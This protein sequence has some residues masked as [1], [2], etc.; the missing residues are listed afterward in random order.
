MF[1]KHFGHIETE[2]KLEWLKTPNH[3]NLPK[4]YKAIANA[5]SKYRNQ[6]GFKKSN[7]HLQC[8]IV[9]DEQKL[10]IEYDE[11]QHFTKA[12]KITLE[13]YPSSIYLSYPKQSWITACEKI[14]AKDNSPID[15]DEKRAFYDTVRDIEAFNNGYTLIR[16]KHGDIDWEADGAEKYL[17]KLLPNKYRNNKTQTTKHKIARLIVTGKQ[18]DRSGNPIYKR[19][20]KLLE[21][22]V[23]KIYMKQQFEFILTP[24][25]FLTFEFPKNLHYNIDVLKALE[26]QIPIFQIEANKVISKFFKELRKDTFKKLKEIADYFTIGIDGYNPKN[27]QLIERKYIIQLVAIYDLKREKVIRWTGKFY[28]IEGEKRKL[29]KIN[30]LNTHFIKLNNQNVVILGC[31]DLN[32]YS[33][34]GQ[35][36]AKPVG[37]KKKLANKF[38]KLNK[39]FKPDIILQHPHTTDSPNI[40]NLAWRAVEKELPNVRH[41]ASGIKYY[42]KSVVVRGDLDKVLEKTKKGDVIDFDFN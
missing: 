21:K 33:P 1:Q 4:E 19:L 12:R 7:Y 11:N 10:I 41:F 36:N 14:N 15:R 27:D 28:P 6:N 2:K 13:N 5:L 30:D 29:V 17:H 31:H 22:F 8:D 20:E 26:K 39:Q 3:N 35:A 34:R 37:W 16:I 9:L 23:S 40:W 38:K 24:G 32:I 25:G 42:N 18:Y